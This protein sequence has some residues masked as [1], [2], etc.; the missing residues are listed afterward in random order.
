MMEPQKYSLWL[1]P[2]GEFFAR[3]AAIIRELSLNQP[4]LCF[5]PHVTLLG[6][7]LGWESELVS[8]TRV[9]ASLIKPY[10]IQLDKVDYL[11][12]FFRSLFIRVEPTYPVLDANRKAQILFRGRTDAEYLPH[13]SLMYGD[14][15][16]AAKEE[17]TVRIGRDFRGEFEVKAIYLYR[18]EGEP[19]DWRQVE[20][21]PLQ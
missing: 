4:A 7:L 10:Q 16:A 15:S 2:V 17:I 20:R 6:K 14:L 11:D 19:K 3:L 1:M 8:K 13:L 5:E 12:E 18:T 9:L 21:F